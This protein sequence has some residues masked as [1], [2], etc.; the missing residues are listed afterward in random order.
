MHHGSDIIDYTAD[1]AKY[2]TR[3]TKQVSQSAQQC[4]EV[5]DGGSAPKCIQI[6][7]V[8]YSPKRVILFLWVSAYPKIGSHT[9][10]SCHMSDIVNI[11]RSS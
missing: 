4:G 1:D 5:A 6:S 8:S 3:R 7:S 9:Q 10:C 2:Y 11:S